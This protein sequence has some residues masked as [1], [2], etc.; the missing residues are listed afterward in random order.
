MLI[1]KTCTQLDCFQMFSLELLSKIERIGVLLS[2]YGGAVFHMF[3]P[4]T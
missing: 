2:V 1:A 3:I 4:Y